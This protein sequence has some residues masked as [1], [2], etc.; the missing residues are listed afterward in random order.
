MP[1]RMDAQEEYRPLPLA[2]KARVTMRLPAADRSA[3][4]R[5]GAGRPAVKARHRITG[6]LRTIRSG[7]CQPPPTT[8]RAS[9]ARGH[10]PGPGPAPCT[11]TEAPHTVAPRSRPAA[12]PRTPIASGRPGTGRAW[13]TLC[14]GR[15]RCAATRPRPA[16]RH[17]C[18]RRASSQPGTSVVTARPAQPARGPDRPARVARPTQL[19]M[20]DRRLSRQG[21]LPTP[22]DRL[23][24]GLGSGRV[25]VSAGDGTLSQP[26]GSRPV[27]P[28]CLGTT[29]R[30]PMVA[31]NLLIRC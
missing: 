25:L 31:P 13:P 3:C 7:A 20:Q 22:P 28:A 1:I 15:G 24:D 4:R 9:G 18:T 29:P 17:R 10:G 14:P 2:V 5:A 11:A 26:G 6:A 12:C 16:S 30:K 8:R 19:T 21:R 23:P 27:A